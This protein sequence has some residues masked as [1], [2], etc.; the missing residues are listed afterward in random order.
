[1][2]AGKPIP[3]RPA[4]ELADRG[5]KPLEGGRSRGD[6][7]L[8]FL[9][10]ARGKPAEV[11]IA[12]LASLN[13]D[14]TSPV[15]HAVES[16]KESGWEAVQQVLFDTSAKPGTVLMSVHYLSGDRAHIA[17]LEGSK[18]A[19]DRR[20]AQIADILESWK[21]TGHVDESL[22]GSAAVWDD[23]RSAA[24]DAFI[25]AGMQK[26]GVPGA[27]VGL[28]CRG[29]PHHLAGF[30][31]ARAGA[32]EAVGPDT[33]FRIG[34]TTKSLTTVMMARMV[35]QGIFAWDTPVCELWPAFSLADPRLTRELRMRH[36]VNASTGMPRRDLAL[37]FRFGGVT[38]EQRL[39]ELREMAPTT[40]LGEVFQY[41]N[42]LV[43]LGGFVAA[44]TAYP[45]LDLADAYSR[46]MSEWVF[47][48]LGMSGSSISGADAP[49]TSAV[50]PHA[51]D[52]EGGVTA[53][54][55]RLEHLVDAVAPAGAAWSSAVDMVKYLTLELNG[56]TLENGRR[57]V[58][59]ASLAARRTGGIKITGTEAYGLGLMN[60]TSLGVDL[61]HHGGNTLGFTSDL[62]FLPDLGIGAALLANLGQAN[63]FREAVRR[64]I[65][66]LAFDLEPKAEAMMAGAKETLT[67]VLRERRGRTSR[68]DAATDWL[69]SFVG[70]YDNALLGRLA[71]GSDDDGV[72][73]RFP[74]VTTAL[75]VS[76]RSDDRLI[77]LASPPWSGALS[78][79]AAPESPDLTLAMGQESYVYR[80]L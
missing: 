55:D 76:T 23:A 46:A 44:K 57:L 47:Q 69:R 19:V 5:A 70:D 80:R 7:S 18:A 75:A 22:T 64:R 52:L 54:D 42:H 59:G 72:W 32:G 78:L 66:E 15:L 50:A 33:A 62:F 41:S 35:E 9:V 16:P 10:M 56:G 26:L 11:A 73:A 65:L 17:V 38:P 12:A 49:P 34:S 8:T 53:I 37:M 30:G 20:G 1:M 2:P 61:L 36:T 60:N 45:S 48:P 21:P 63:G 14:R 79:R 6:V 58:S 77:S 29:Q 74:D 13:P 27:C 28:V 4:A 25:L 51:L 67:G 39:E 24:L 68:G 3:L 43:A 40:G 71:I 31:V